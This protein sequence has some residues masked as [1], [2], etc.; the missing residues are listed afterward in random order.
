MKWPL[1]QEVCK[2]ITMFLAS[3]MYTIPNIPCILL[4][5]SSGCQ[6]PGVIN[7]INLVMKLAHKCKPVIKAE[8]GTGPMRIFKVSTAFKI[9]EIFSLFLSQPGRQKL[10]CQTMT[11][12]LSFK[13][14]L[15]KKH[16]KMHDNYLIITTT[17]R[18][19]K[20]NNIK[21]RKLDAF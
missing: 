21:K 7:A 20:K 14:L 9:W 17:L 13:H 3:F 19:N 16:A 1:D 2:N 8:P 15:G 12:A 6:Y 4:L 18:K 5:E 11:V 10:S